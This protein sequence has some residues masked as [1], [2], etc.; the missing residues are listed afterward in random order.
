MELL[1]IFIRFPLAALL[2]S[3]VFVF[4]F[5]HTRKTLPGVVAALWAL[6][7]VYEYLM[8]TRVL[9]SGECNIRVDLLLIYPVLLVLTISGIV[10]AIRRGTGQAR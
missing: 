6:Y 8:H 7:A 2:V 5:L 4:L 10:I 1:S 3:G 9:C